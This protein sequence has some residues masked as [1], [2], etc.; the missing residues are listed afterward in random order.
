MPKTYAVYAAGN[1]LVDIT[2]STAEAF[3]VQH[4]LKKGTMTLV[5]KEKQEKLLSAL[6]SVSHVQQSGGS[7]ANTLVAL[8]QLGPKSFYACKVG[9]DPL[10]HFYLQNLRESGVLSAENKAL[11][12]GGTTGT[13]LVCVTPDAERTMCTFLGVTQHF[14]KDIL[15]TDALR[16]ATWLYMEGY[17]FMGEKSREALRTAYAFS[18][19]E[20]VRT[21]LSLSDPAVVAHSRTQLLELLN[22]KVDLL[23]CNTE[24]AQLLTQQQEIRNILE[25][26]RT[27][28]DQFVVTQGS[29]GAWACDGY[30]QQHIPSYPAAPVDTNGAGDMFAGVCLY[31]LVSGKSLFEAAD[32]A[33]LASARLVETP[34]ARLASTAFQELKKHKSF[35]TSRAK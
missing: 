9:D 11:Y 29:Q 24:E 31:G 13:C 23:F 7:A 2:V 8:S 28:A 15:D 1:A 17:L 12:K 4:G 32:M 16:H 33:A 35:L 10:G 30:E 26:L 20:G 3:L 22:T 19:K 18:Q 14:S 25:C 27:Y 5:S 21:A 34:G 6:A